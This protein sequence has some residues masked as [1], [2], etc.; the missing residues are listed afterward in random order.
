VALPQLT[1][2]FQ[3][4]GGRGVEQSEELVQRFARELPILPEAP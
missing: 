3:R 2:D 1:V 4:I